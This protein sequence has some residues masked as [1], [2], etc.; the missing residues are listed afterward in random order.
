[1]GDM[2]FE[3]GLHEY[4]LMLSYGYNMANGG[5]FEKEVQVNGGWIRR[6]WIT[7]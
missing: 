5:V 4:D 6:Y 3:E 7:L 2:N 1:M